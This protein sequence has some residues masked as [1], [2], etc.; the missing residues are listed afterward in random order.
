MPR[1]LDDAD[2]SSDLGIE[3][4]DGEEEEEDGGEAGVERESAILTFTESSALSDVD[5]ETVELLWWFVEVHRKRGNEKE[6]GVS[7]LKEAVDAIVASFFY[8]LQV[9]W[10]G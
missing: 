7:D 1:S 10:S 3:K 4:C 9:R 6:W 2:L 8:L 5:W